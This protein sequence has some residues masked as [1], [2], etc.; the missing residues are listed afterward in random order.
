MEPNNDGKVFVQVFE[1]KLGNP[2]GG[3]KV[4]GVQ[5]GVKD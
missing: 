3:A 4:M 1:D 5:M 2:V